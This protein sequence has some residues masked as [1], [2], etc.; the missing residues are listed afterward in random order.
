VCDLGEW[1]GGG[2]EGR[3]DIRRIRRKNRIKKYSKKER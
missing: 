3:K 2:K 1:D